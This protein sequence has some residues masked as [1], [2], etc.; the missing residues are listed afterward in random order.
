MLVILYFC[1]CPLGTGKTDRILVSTMAPPYIMQA[2]ATANIISFSRVPTFAAP[3]LFVAL[4][5]A[6]TSHLFMVFLNKIAPA[7]WSDFLY[8]PGHKVVK[9]ITSIYGI[10]FLSHRGG[11]NSLSPS[12]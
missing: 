11:S 5:M 12:S 6:G 7:F 8:S 1:F 9:M 3:N 4:L 10:S 2:S